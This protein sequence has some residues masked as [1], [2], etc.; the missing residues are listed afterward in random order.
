MPYDCGIAITRHPSAHRVAMGAHAA[1]LIESGDGPPDPV[2]LVPEFS[3]RA[4]G[5]PVYAALRSLGRSGVADL[6][7]RLLPS[8]AQEYAAALRRARRRRGASTTWC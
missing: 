8:R 4:R 1:Y 2:E 7:E 5:V 6:V 3:R